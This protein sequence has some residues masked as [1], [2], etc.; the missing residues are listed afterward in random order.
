MF[1]STFCELDGLK[2]KHGFSDEYLSTQISVSEELFHWM[3]TSNR[4][5]NSDGSLI[6]HFHDRKDFC[7]CKAFHISQ[8]SVCLNIFVV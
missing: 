3:S 7:Y 4:Q 6:G 1:S 2:E 5:C 8:P